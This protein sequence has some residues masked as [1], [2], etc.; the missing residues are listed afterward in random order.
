MK[1]YTRTG[2]QGK[3]GLFG[4]QRIRKDSPR[5][6]AYG[7]VDECN[8]SLGIVRALLD[9]ADLESKLIQVQSE[10]F[11]VGADLAT[12]SVEG[13]AA[14]RVPRVQPED[15]TWLERWIDEAEAE[16]EPMRTFILPGG[17]PTAAHLHLAR[18]IAR[19]AER[20][21]VGLER[22]ETINPHVRVYL[23][24]LSDLLFVWARL[25]NQRAGLKE[26]PWTA[27]TRTPGG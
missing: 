15:V 26:T 24:R 13:K 2:D 14:A 20:R 11:V 23:N 10:L 12:P 4:G 7:T 19:R 17:T 18:T 5:V 9:D 25:I 8:A 1:I 21:V 27:P 16:L 22:V 6:E 3:T